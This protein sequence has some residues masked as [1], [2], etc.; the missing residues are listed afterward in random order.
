MNIL[1]GRC[2]SETVFGRCP[3]CGG[4]LLNGHDCPKRPAAEDTSEVTVPK[5]HP[6]MARMI[7]LWAAAAEVQH[8]TLA[9]AWNTNGATVSRF[10]TGKHVP[11][12][13]TMARIIAWLFEPEEKP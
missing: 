7:R 6:K 13:R 2:D 4:S 5:D 9:K 3:Y 12:G 8:E 1:T 11:D 10:L